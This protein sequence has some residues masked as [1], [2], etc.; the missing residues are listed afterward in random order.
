M[1]VK[2]FPLASNKRKLTSFHNH[3][4][5]KYQRS[6][7]RNK[8]CSD[9][10]FVFIFLV[11]YNNFVHSPKQDNIWFR[12]R[13]MLYNS[14]QFCWFPINQGAQNENNTFPLLFFLLNLMMKYCFSLNLSFVIFRL[15]NISSRFGQTCISQF[16][17]LF[18]SKISNIINWEYIFLKFFVVIVFIFLPRH[19][20]FVG[21]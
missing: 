19:R 1:C 18:V 3:R 9:V 20:F 6:Q 10:V 7:L 16:L 8:N 13:E 12:C 4:L 15:K 11:R 21:S 17:L 5:A 2:T 14:F